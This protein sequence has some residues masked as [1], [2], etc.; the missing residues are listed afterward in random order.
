MTIADITDEYLKVAGLERR[1]PDL[2]FLSELT[3]RHLANFSFSSVGPMLGDELPL[4]VE[5]VYR[6]IVVN[7]RGGY[8]F[9]QNG[10]MQAVLAELGFAVTL[11]LARVIH[12]QDT[13]PGLTHRITLVE[14]AGK[15]YVADV[16]FGSTGPRFPV[17]MTGEE[18]REDFRVFRIAEG[19]PGEYHMQILKDGS[20]FSL[21]RFERHR[22]GQSDCELGHFYSHKHPRANFV[23]H[24][25]VSRILAGEVRSLRNHELWL[26]R[27]DGEERFTIT[28]SA[29]LRTELH[30]RF[31]IDVDESEAHR[32]FQRSAGHAVTNAVTSR[33]A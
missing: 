19:R 27:A 9:E 16:G 15:Q 6:R 11:C 24:L 8:C 5:A 21:Y 25:V 14:I 10:L 18:V 26:I 13:H 20:Y 28:D 17:G 1:P 22:Y 3:S 4:D 12:N 33:S 23:N 7:H 31:D 29:Q 32:L 2:A 30:D